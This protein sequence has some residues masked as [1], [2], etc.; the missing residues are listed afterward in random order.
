MSY[1]VEAALRHLLEPRAERPQLPP[2]PSY[3]MGLPLVDIADRD[4]LYEAMGD[5]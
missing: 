1:L 3:R 2:L 5:D 4:A